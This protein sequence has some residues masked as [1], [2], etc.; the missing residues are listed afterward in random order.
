MKV[1]ESLEIGSEA[2]QH[3]FN[4]FNKPDMN[5]HLAFIKT[6]FSILSSSITKLEAQGL[7]LIQSMGIIDSVKEKINDVPGQVGDL[8]RS[9]LDFVLGNN[10]GF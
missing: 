7:P 6:H 2:M 4:L 1:I 10:P 8:I 5:Q 3:S 9:K